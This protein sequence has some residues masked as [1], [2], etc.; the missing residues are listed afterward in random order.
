MRGDA[1][2][3]FGVSCS[4]SRPTRLCLPRRCLPLAVNATWNTD[5]CDLSGNPV[6]GEDG[7]EYTNECV[8]PATLQA[9]EI[10]ALKQHAVPRQG[11]L[12]PWQTLSGAATG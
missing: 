9:H 8:G 12:E 10:A 6:C 5:E 3:L 2:G 4:C 11:R 1:R 7:I